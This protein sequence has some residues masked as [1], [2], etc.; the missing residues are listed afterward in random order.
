MTGW[1]R[2]RLDLHIFVGRNRCML[3]RSYQGA[4]EPGVDTSHHMK[5]GHPAAADRLS[6]AAK[7]EWGKTHSRS[8]PPP[9]KHTYAFA[10]CS[11]SSVTLLLYQNIPRHEQDSH[12]HKNISAPPNTC[13]ST[14]ASAQYWRESA[15]RG[16][17]FQSAAVVTQQCLCW[18]GTY[19]L[20][21]FSFL[22][23]L[24]R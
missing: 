7:W 9:P 8:P 6:S 15:S 18:R 10:V 22:S 3:V 1:L 13:C 19:N 4:T 2:C 24:T 20:V 11:L 17:F 21:L 5:H 14:A 16:P 23:L 12:A